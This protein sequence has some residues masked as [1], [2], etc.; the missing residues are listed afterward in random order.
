[1][2][3]QVSKS[4][5]VPTIFINRKVLFVFLK[6]EFS[7]RNFWRDK[8]WKFSFVEKAVGSQEIDVFWFYNVELAAIR[9]LC[10]C[11]Y[12]Q[13]NRSES[14]HFKVRIR[15]NPGQIQVIFWLY[16][17]FR[18]YYFFIK[19]V[20]SG[21]LRYG[22]L[23]DLYLSWDDPYLRRLFLPKRTKTVLF[24]VFYSVIS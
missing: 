24:Q 12:L 17:I 20:N 8:D 10:K 11:N 13:I 14:G 7:S 19:I 15:S 22:K 16:P 23:D 21:F 18:I 4:L 1:M 9:K 5:S 6:I 2:L 3:W